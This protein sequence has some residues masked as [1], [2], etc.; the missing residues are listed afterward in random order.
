MNLVGIAPFHCAMT[1]FD[2][3][4]VLQVRMEECAVTQPLPEP[5]I[6]SKQGKLLNRACDPHKYLC[7]TYDEILMTDKN[8]SYLT[9]RNQELNLAF[10]PRLHGSVGKRSFLLEHESDCAQVR[11]GIM[12]S[13]LTDKVWKKATI[14]TD[15]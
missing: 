12:A 9:Y 3:Q 7:C 13:R 2:P 10:Y 6:K 8:D 4:L 5:S 1:Q 14:Q 11:F 15:A